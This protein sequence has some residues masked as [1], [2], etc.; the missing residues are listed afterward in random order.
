MNAAEHY[1]NGVLQ[2]EGDDEVNLVLNVID[3]ASVAEMRMG[4]PKNTV[5]ISDV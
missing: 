3:I 2:L 5:A 4:C 1:I